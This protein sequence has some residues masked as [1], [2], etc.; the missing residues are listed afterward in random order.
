MKMKTIALILV[1]LLM[2]M[3]SSF[4]QWT[5]TNLSDRKHWMGSAVLGTKV[6]FAGGSIVAD[7]V[8]TDKVE[9]YDLAAGIWE[10]SRLSVARAGV[11][12]A[13]CGTRV[14]FGG[15]LIYPSTF[16]ATVDVFDTITKEWSVS[17]LSAPRFSMSAVSRGDLVLFAGGNNLLLNQAYDVVDIYNNLTGTWST[18]TLSIPRGAMAS[19]VVG[20]LAIFAGGY[21]N[22]TF[23][24]RVDIYNFT[25]KTWTTASLSQARGFASAAVLGSKV[26]IAGGISANNTPSDRI[27]IYDASA[28]SWTTASLS[29]PRGGEKTAV[30][31]CGKVFFAGG[32]NFNTNTKMWSNSSNV[33]DIYDETT[34]S[35]S[36]DHTT[37]SLMFHS[38]ESAGDQLVIAGGHSAT[39]TG[40]EHFK[41]VEIFT[42]RAGS[43]LPRGIS[44]GTQAEIDGFQ[45]AHTSCTRID[46]NVVIHGNNIS[47]LSGLDRVDAIGGDL[48]I[49]GN[50]S[51]ASLSGLKVLSFIGG[52]M[53]IYG[54][55][56]ITDLTGLDSL[57]YLGGDLTVEGNA[58]LQSLKGLGNLSPGSIKNLYIVSNPLLKSCDVKSVCDLL[59]DPKGTIEISDNSSG[60]NS[61]AEVESK[62][63]AG[64]GD[65]QLP[66]S[67]FAV[68]SD[69]VGKSIRIVKPG[70]LNVDEVV[71]YSMTG[72]R[73][74]II[75]PDNNIIDLSKLLQGTYIVQIK[76][77]QLTK[78]LKINIL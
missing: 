26:F 38:V 67:D 22:T 16:F 30:T 63:R 57:D 65:I 43:C 62:C 51:L 20:D 55:D 66:G 73:I 45:A 50:P 3:L 37:N 40:S 69:P 36:T 10:T 74:L 23:T 53:Y 2:P 4:G 46:G 5:Q 24:D 28:G 31:A 47:D 1:A 25:T 60:C 13:V 33:I 17:Q 78:R 58:V 70:D 15:G 71:V 54:N 64:I 35:W 44:F 14:L 27:D 42:C 29:T 72:N 12:G 11:V 7:N 19:A 75:Y 48:N 18:A 59:A 32:G 61:P 21:N 8:V 9:I 77:G 39:P 41:L 52:N 34:N 6:Y 76:A 68:Y 56:L 49:W